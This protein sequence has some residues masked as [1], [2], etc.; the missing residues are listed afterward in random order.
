MRRLK[1]SLMAEIER[2]RQAAS[3]GRET[4]LE[5]GVFILWANRAGDAWLLEITD[6]DA[7][8]VA[9]GGEPL[10]I[11]IDENP[12]TIAIQWSHNFAIRDRKFYLTSYDDKGETCLEEAPAKRIHAAMRR[13][14]KKYSAEQLSRVHVD[15]P[16]QSSATG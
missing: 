2:I 7:V 10:P 13:I 1:I 15:T 6:N 8:Q 14:R 4:V 5:L 3:D 11:D 12:E 9:G 16:P